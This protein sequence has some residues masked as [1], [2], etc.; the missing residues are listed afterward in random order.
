MLTT[1]QEEQLYIEVLDNYKAYFANKLSFVDQ[2]EE[3]NFFTLVATQIRN[4]KNVRIPF[5]SIYGGNVLTVNKPV[6]FY[7]CNPGGS[8]NCLIFIKNGVNFIPVGTVISFNSTISIDSSNNFTN[9]VLLTIFRDSLIVPESIT[10]PVESSQLT[11]IYC[12]NVLLFTNA[13][14]NHFAN[15]SEFN[16][17]TGS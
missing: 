8:E 4:L 2:T 14:I 6:E 3:D 7:I 1:E 10:I 11:D 17:I 12:A 5:M 15:T 9:N 13:K 16:T